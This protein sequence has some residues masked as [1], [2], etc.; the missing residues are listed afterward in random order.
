M[1]SDPSQQHISQKF[2]QDLDLIRSRLQT[3][4]GLAERQ[5]ETAV[6]AF[7]GANSD[8]AQQVRGREHDIDQMETDIDALC[9]RVMALRQP[10]A[11]DLRLLL[12]VGHAVND[13]ERIG[14]EANRLAKL[15]LGFGRTGAPGYAT[16][17]VDQLFALTREMLH[18]V[19][20]AFASLDSAKALEIVRADAGVNDVYRAA[21][22]SV[23]RHMGEN[24]TAVG[25]L[26]NVVWALRSLE[27]VGDH[28]RNVAEHVIYVVEGVDVRHTGIDHIASVVVGARRESGGEPGPPAGA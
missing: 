2:D 5:L 1:A 18:G 21:T 20:D 13:L 11:K 15:V 24:P 17:S 22:D 26:I 8:L 14:D 25:S 23:T 3:M 19:L 12:A 7:V 16:D 4:G 27:R 28:A 9:M 10:I 6:A